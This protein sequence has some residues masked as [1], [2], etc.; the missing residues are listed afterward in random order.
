MALAIATAS[1]A[2]WAVVAAGGLIG[3]A[4]R[5]AALRRGTRVQFAAVLGFVVFLGLGEV[6]I[7]R[8]ALEPRLI[9]MHRQEGAVYPENRAHRELQRMDVGRF[10][11][12]EASLSLFAAVAAGLGLSLLVTRAPQAVVA[13]GDGRDTTA[14]AGV[15]LPAPSSAEPDP[16]DDLFAL[17]TALRF[18]EDPSAATEE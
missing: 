3:L 15:F 12:I 18:A 5:C 10:L 13:F 4:A 17:P 8:Q 6:L 11:H 7:Y 9:E 16:D 14:S 2:V 1:S